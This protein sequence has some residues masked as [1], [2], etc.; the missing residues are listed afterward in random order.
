MDEWDVLYIESAC[1]RGANCPSKNKKDIPRTKSGP[2]DL[3]IV[4]SENVAAAVYFNQ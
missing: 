1:T 3:D 2:I 4:L